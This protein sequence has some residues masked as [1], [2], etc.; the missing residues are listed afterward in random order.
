M[1]IRSPCVDL[2]VYF[3]RGEEEEVDQGGTG[4]SWQLV[5]SLAGKFEHSY[6]TCVPDTCT[7]SV[8]QVSL[9]ASV[10][11]LSA[12]NSFVHLLTR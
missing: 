8:L 6:A 4:G 9:S 7:D 1:A 3:N 11:C 2:C 5:K 12:S 10:Q